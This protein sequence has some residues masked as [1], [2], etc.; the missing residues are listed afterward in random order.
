MF[1]YFRFTNHL[2]KITTTMKKAKKQNIQKMPKVIQVLKFSENSNFDFIPLNKGR[3][4]RKLWNDEETVYL[5]I[6]V[7]I[8]G[9]GNWLNIFK[10]FSKTFVEK[11][12][13]SLRIR[14][15]TINKDKNK[16]SKQFSLAKKVILFEIII[17]C[18]NRLYSQGNPN[19][20]TKC[21]TI[22]LTKAYRKVFRLLYRY[23]LKRDHYR[24]S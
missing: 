16:F 4:D 17:S 7:Y 20:N 8:E 2:K 24:V 5:I 9:E 11:K 23:I 18:M 10:L 1:K 22:A 21:V 15:N 12:S 6:G 13:D 19:S 14:W 3:K